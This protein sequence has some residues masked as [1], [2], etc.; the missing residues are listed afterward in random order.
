MS[1]DDFVMALSASQAFC[2]SAFISAS[3][4]GGLYISQSGRLS[5]A[6]NGKLP[7]SRDDSAVIRTRL[8][9]VSISTWLS[10]GIVYWY[11]ANDNN[12]RVSGPVYLFTIFH[13][14]LVKYPRI[15][16]ESSW[17]YDAE[18]ILEGAFLDTPSVY[19]SVRCTLSVATTSFSKILVN[20]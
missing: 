19:G 5:Y 18:K 1:R 14:A 6:Q 11:I 3:Y 20:K 16:F 9:A 4:V 7:S 17:P 8:K 10:C 13:L 15:H 2:V 12:N